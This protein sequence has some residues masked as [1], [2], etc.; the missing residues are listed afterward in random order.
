MAGH[1]QSMAPAF[2]VGKGS[3]TSLDLPAASMREDG[4]THLDGIRSEPAAPP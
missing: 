1:R 3:E 4:C 2:A